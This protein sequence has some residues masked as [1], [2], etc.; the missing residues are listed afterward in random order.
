M[1]LHISPLFAC[2]VLAWAN[3]VLGVDETDQ[4]QS[5]GVLAASE[6][7]ADVATPAEPP[8]EPRFLLRYKFHAGQLLRWKIEHLEVGVGAKTVDRRQGQAYDHVHRNGHSG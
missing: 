7:A 2:A 8:T 3:L 5:A 1:K 6:P 4:A